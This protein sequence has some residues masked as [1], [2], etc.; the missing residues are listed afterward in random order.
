MQ[1]GRLVSHSYRNTANIAF[2]IIQKYT[3]KKHLS[4]MPDV[5][6]SWLTGYQRDR[7]GNAVSVSLGRIKLVAATDPLRTAGLLTL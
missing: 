1:S 5:L 7:L 6:I 3:D 2:G 4:L